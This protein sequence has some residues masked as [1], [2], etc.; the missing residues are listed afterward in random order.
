MICKEVGQPD[1]DRCSFEA[2][3][4]FDCLLRKKVSKFGDITDNLGAC[5]HHISNMK[6]ALGHADLLDKHL[7]KL[8]YMPQSFI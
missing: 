6:Q 7:T 8:N 1:S 2:R 3:T 4:A 5:K